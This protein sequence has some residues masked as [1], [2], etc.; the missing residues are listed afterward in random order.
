MVSFCNSSPF[1][2]ARILSLLLLSFYVASLRAAPYPPDG[3]ASQWTQPDGTILKLRMFGDEFYARTETEEG[4]TVVFDQEQQ[5]YYFAR[6]SDDGT[7]LE[8][9]GTLA[10]NAATAAQAEG[11]AVKL[12][13]EEAQRIWEAN[14]EKWVP[15]EREE[16]QK[17]VEAARQKRQA[18]LSPTEPQN[19]LAEP[20]G[21]ET[22]EYAVTGGY[23][24]LTILVQF[25]DDP[26]TGTTDPTNFPTTRTKVERYCN[27]LG[28]T[29]DGNTGSV[30]DYFSDQSLGAVDYTQEVTQIVTLPHPRN[31]YNYSDYPTNSILQDNGLAGNQ[32][33]THA[34][35]ELQSQGYDFSNISTASNDY[36]IAT[37]ILFAGATSGVW[38]EGLWPHRWSI[39]TGPINVGTTQNPRYVFDYQITN[40]QTS[41]LVIGTFCHENGHLLLKVTDFYDTNSTN[42]SSE[43]IGEHGLM[44]SGNHLNGGK[45]P[46]P[47]SAYVKD[48]SGWMNITDLTSSSYTLETLATNTNQAYRI[49]KPGSLTEYFLIE[50]RGTGD[51]WAAAT[52][53][54][55]IM[56]WHVDETVNGNKNQQMTSS[57]HY[58]LSIEQA[59][60]L[61]DLENDRDRGDSADMFDV[62]DGLFDDTTLPDARWWDG[63]ASGIHISVLDPPG[64][65]MDVQFGAQPPNTVTIQ[66]PL[67]GAKAFTGI[68]TAINWIGTFLPNVTIDLYK[69]GAFHSNIVTNTANDGE[70]TWIPDESIPVGNDYT[71]RVRNVANSSIDAY[72]GTF[73]IWNGFFFDGFES[74]SF[75]SDWTITGTNTHRTIITTANGPLFGARHAT[76]DSNT[77]L[78]FARNEMTTSLNLRRKQNVVLRFYAKEFGDEE[79][80]PPSA[81][82]SG[83]ANFDGV[84]VSEDGNL[85]YEVQPL[86]SEISSTWQEFAV[87]LDAAVATYGLT[88]T[89]NFRIRFNHYDNYAIDTDGFAFDNILVYGEAAPP[90]NTTVDL[91]SASDTGYSNTDN[92]TQD[93]TPTFS[94][95]TEPDVIVTL[96]SNISGVIG[97]A[98]SNGSGNWSLTSSVTLPQGVH[99]ISATGEATSSVLSVTIDTTSPGLTIDEAATQTDPASSG[100]VRFSAVFT[101]PVSGFTN[102][103]VNASGSA[104]GSVSVSGGPSNYTVSV[105]ATSSEGYVQI[106]VGSGIASDYAGNSSTAPTVTDA[107]VVLDGHGND[108]FNGTPLVISSDTATES[109]WLTPSDSD[110]FQ[111]TLDTARIID[112]YTTGSQNTVG[113]IRDYF[114][115][116]VNDPVA[117]DDA[118]TGQNFSTHTILL[119]GTYTVEVANGNGGGS[120]NYGLVLTTSDPPVLINEVDSYTWN[121]DTA[122]FVELFD[123]GVGNAPLDGLVLVFYQ[124]DDQTVVNAIDLDGELTDSNGYFLLGNA[125]VAGADLTLPDSSIGDGYDAVALYQ[126]DA[127]EFTVGTALTTNNLID[128]IVYLADETSA[129]G[130]LLPLLAP[131]ETEVDED[132]NTFALGQSLQRIPDGSGG[133]RIT[134]EIVAAAPTPGAPN[135][136]PGPPD[137]IDLPDTSDS[138][139]PNTDNLTNVTRPEFSGTAT[140]GTL[141]KISSHRSGVLGIVQT[142]SDGTY[143]LPQTPSDLPEGP[144]VITAS[145]LSTGI[146]GASVTIT[147]DTTPTGVTV[148]QAPTQDDPTTSN[149][150]EFVATFDAPVIGFEADDVVLTGSASGIVT[151]SGGPAVYNISVDSSNE[152]GR[153]SV[154]LPAGV[155]TD[156]IGNANAPSTSTDNYVS[157]DIYGDFASGTQ[158]PVQLLSG[159]IDLTG[160]VN[161]GDHDAFAFTIDKPKLA[162]IQT[163]GDVDTVGAIYKEDGTRLNTPGLD[164][165]S[166]TGRNFLISVPLA[167]G[168]YIVDIYSQGIYGNGFYGL[169][170]DASSA[171]YVQPDL[172]VSSSNASSTPMGADV[173]DT[174]S[175]QTFTLNSRRAS[176]VAGKV[177]LQNDGEVPDNFFVSASRGNALY[178]VRYTTWKDGNIT[179]GLISG[180]HFES[181]VGIGEE[182]PTIIAVVQP[183]KRKLKKTTKRRL[184]N[185]KVKKK[186]KWLKKTF[187]LNMTATSDASGE[188]Q[189]VARLVIRSY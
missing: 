184:R 7:K 4:R 148:E 125:G 173:Y 152:E 33:V 83:G 123:G 165:N 8:S 178:S 121:G 183:N 34:V 50:N 53:D 75:S 27:E 160:W 24:G 59:D 28:Y 114:G 109:G 167:A 128:A 137:T 136:L 5:A 14:H 104:A 108:R 80:G 40:A 56:I 43:G 186:T 98:T 170:I 3:L 144:H 110:F 187:N 35:A 157:L 111:F 12:P 162:I 103:D 146:A 70:Y 101:E 181:D 171:P 168:T 116:I 2:V 68:A 69:G 38:S 86:R 174:F 54:Q 113:T 67:S 107:N 58:E 142:G 91:S 88:Y 30:R 72:S 15:N 10:E 139:N 63:S 87:D 133:P 169:T 49:Y 1:P 85:W 156:A 32:I 19:A 175:G 127:A 16:W 94:G 117:D 79:D 65:N 92:I 166:G 39:Q 29:D 100:P 26:A 147:I 120:G 84:A 143:D 122:E 149:P 112:L 61:F 99:Q 153:L 106:S 132:E 134:S 20:A 36:I 47:L 6:L 76:M 118:G 105:S 23:V 179:A 185:G 45:T 48:I 51:P 66:S 52:R 151:V 21:A 131:S 93:T 161:V 150:I 18:N 115:N 13:P 42:G 89:S 17:R 82:F 96:V 102:S 44:G 172:M 124:G 95:V 130:L 31:W 158:V 60:G 163:S 77:D 90:A 46:A 37:N 145:T 11:G 57:L 78:T 81:P 55:G 159:I 62:N 138:G 176:P 73:E 140:P 141:V 155:V 129:D 180:T 189:D 71:I 126:A 119:A 188:K 154:S 25:P 177:Q 9:A 164:D 135:Q 97:M 41:S 74:T 64:Q 22:V 182:S